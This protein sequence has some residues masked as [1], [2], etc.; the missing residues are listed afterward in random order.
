MFQINLTEI[1]L[2]NTIPKYLETSVL[3]ER[4][5]IPFLFNNCILNVITKD[6]NA[7][8]RNIINVFVHN[9]RD[10]DYS[11]RWIHEHLRFNVEL[12]RPFSLN[13]RKEVYSLHEAHFDDFLIDKPRN[14]IIDEYIGY[15]DFPNLQLVDTEIV[16]AKYL[17][18][19]DPYLFV[20]AT[21][22]QRCLYSKFVDTT[23]FLNEKLNLELMDVKII[24]IG[25]IDGFQLKHE[26]RMFRKYSML[27][28]AKRKLYQDFGK[29]GVCT[30]NMLLF[31][32]DKRI[33]N[34]HDREML[35]SLVHISPGGSFD[36]YSIRERE[37]IGNGM[38]L[39]IGSLLDE[40]V[41]HT[42][43]GLIRRIFESVQSENAKLTLI[44][45]SGAYG[46][47]TKAYRRDFDVL[48]KTELFGFVMGVGE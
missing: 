48:S 41:Y 26:E 14:I 47:Y 8:W 32:L 10:E 30:E 44:Q 27:E 39:F 38:K 5:D 34:W 45:E 35:N 17:I 42:S 25:S 22:N 20:N 12:N 15:D 3:D 13:I 2:L 19:V 9:G 40:K 24:I 16:G 6:V 23:I 46:A 11:I 31:G 37:T 1:Q 33:L 18:L 43:I 28:D 7:C 21:I 36:F 29:L 4:Q